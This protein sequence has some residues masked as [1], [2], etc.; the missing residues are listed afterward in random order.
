MKGELLLFKMCPELRFYLSNHHN[1]GL[2]LTF[3][4]KQG[5]CTTGYFNIVKFLKLILTLDLWTR[6]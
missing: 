6:T 4:Y 3:E 1:P 2:V 5:D